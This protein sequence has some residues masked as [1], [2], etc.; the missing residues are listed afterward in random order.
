MP[1]Q[2]VTNALLEKHLQEQDEKIDKLVTAV[3][4]NGKPGLKDRVTAIELCMSPIKRFGWI[5]LTALVTTA[6]T[7]IAGLVIVVVK[8]VY[9]T[10]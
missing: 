8:L 7:S 4:G 2:E 1:N 5:V 3:E 9:G 6:C 10:K